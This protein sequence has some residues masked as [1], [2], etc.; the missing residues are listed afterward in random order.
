MPS[1]RGQKNIS[2]GKNNDRELGGK[3][4]MAFRAWLSGAL[5]LTLGACAGGDAAKDP[6]KLDRVVQ[7]KGLLAYVVHDDH[8]IKASLT[9]K[10]GVAAKGR[11]VAIT[12]AQG[13]C[14]GCHALP[15]AETTF[16]QGDIGP[17]LNGIAS[18]MTPAEIRLRIVNPKIVNAATMMPAYYRVEGFHRVAKNRENQSI[19]NPEQ[20]EDLIAFLMT[21]K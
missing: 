16:R 9:G 4:V 1:G 17:P 7:E 11:V 12:G 10:E 19:L 20:I 8:E 13:N 3:T 5:I 21:L 15:D 6:A 18:R 14:V 2:R